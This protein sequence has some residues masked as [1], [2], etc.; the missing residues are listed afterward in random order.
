VTR[1][2]RSPRLRGHTPGDSKARARR[3]SMAQTP[4]PPKRFEDLPD[5]L[6]SPRVEQPVEKVFPWVL[7][8][9]VRATPL[10]PSVFGTNRNVS[11]RPPLPFPLFEYCAVRGAMSLIMGTLRGAASRCCPAAVGPVARRVCRR[12]RRTPSGCST[13]RPTRACLSVRLCMSCS[14]DS[15]G[16]GARA[17]C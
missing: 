12:V 9:A 4:P 16:W 17:R 7:T 5:D 14:I 13:L 8:G 6:F 2:Q 3:L 10:L 11:G 1:T 15:D